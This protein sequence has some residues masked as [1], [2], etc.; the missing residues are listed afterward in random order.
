M[1]TYLINGRRYRVT[2][3]HGKR[4]TANPVA[5]ELHVIPLLDGCPASVLAFAT[6]QTLAK[7]H[8]EAG[9]KTLLISRA[10]LELMEVAA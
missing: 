7:I 10:Q 4:A 9:P 6:V 3:E 2:V 5:V 8:D 1:K